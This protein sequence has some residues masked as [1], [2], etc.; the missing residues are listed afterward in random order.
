VPLQRERCCLKDSLL[1]LTVLIF[2]AD[3]EAD[4]FTP[5]QWVM[6][7]KNET[8]VLRL[9]EGETP[10]NAGEDSSHTASDDLLEGLDER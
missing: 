1:N 6:A 10:R 4:I 2:A 7:F 3:N 5:F 8:F 9:D